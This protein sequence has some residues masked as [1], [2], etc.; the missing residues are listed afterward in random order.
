MERDRLKNRVS[1]LTTLLKAGALSGIVLLAAGLIATAFADESISISCYKDAQSAW[2]VG[3]AVVYNVADAAASC[4]SLYYDCR[5]RCIGC[6]Q[7]SDYIDNVC[8]DMQGR[9]FLK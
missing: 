7:D 2:A 9:T 6:Y 4:N 3:T 1:F 5:G 8:I